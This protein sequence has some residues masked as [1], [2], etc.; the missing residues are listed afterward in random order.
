MGKIYNTNKSYG[1]ITI[2]IHWLM[3]II[4]IGLFILGKYMI[5]LDYYDNYYHIAPW[6]HKSFGLLTA[7]IL[8]FRLIWRGINPKVQALSNHKT[9]E[10][11]LATVMQ[12]ILY[13]LVLTCCISGILISTAEGADISFFDLFKLPSFLSMGG[14]QTEIAE[15]IHEF[16]TTAL[17]VI[18][19]L[20]MLAALKHHFINKDNTLIRILT[21]K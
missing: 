19:S 21:N 8:I 10:I 5:D 15:E 14:E 6:W 3:A 16:A 18:A 4:I 13:L 7:M 12:I 1:L 20:H 9:Y 2:I 17:I 11:K